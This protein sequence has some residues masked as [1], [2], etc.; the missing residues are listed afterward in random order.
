MTNIARLEVMRNLSKA[1][2]AYLILV[3]L[4]VVLLTVSIIKLVAGG[5][6]KRPVAKPKAPTIAK[7]A[8]KAAAPKTSNPAPAT[9]PTP[10]PKPPTKPSTPVLTN[11]GPGDV[12][13][14]FA[15]VSL[16]GATVHYCWLRA[17]QRVAYSAE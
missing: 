10:T 8:P 12:V 3:L 1:T 7:T 14:L 11:S 9:T 5:D 4:I 2:I 15:L 6:D 13:A 16:L 17:K